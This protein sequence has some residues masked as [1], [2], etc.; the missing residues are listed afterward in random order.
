[1]LEFIIK[2][3]RS[4]LGPGAGKMIKKLKKIQKTKKIANI[5]QKFL[6]SKS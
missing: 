1:M 4:S 2:S 5:F 3:W 6:I